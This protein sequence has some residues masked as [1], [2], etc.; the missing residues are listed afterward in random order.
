[1][2]SDY[3]KG[4]VTAKLGWHQQMTHTCDHVVAPNTLAIEWVGPSVV[5]VLV[6]ATE[7]VGCPWF[8]T[9]TCL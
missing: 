9:S 1:V 8:V 2:T 3:N 7:E 4:T 6:V 5:S